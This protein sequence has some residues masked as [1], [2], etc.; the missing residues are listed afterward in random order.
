MA[1]HEA[2][3]KEISL[4]LARVIDQGRTKEMMIIFLYGKNNNNQIFDTW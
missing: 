2:W 4:E 1:L 3:H